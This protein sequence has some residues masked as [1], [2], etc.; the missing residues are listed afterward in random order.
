M[1]ISPT[2]L[3]RITID[4]LQVYRNSY[5]QYPYS[6]INREKGKILTANSELSQ[7]NGFD[8]RNGDYI[9]RVGDVIAKTDSMGRIMGNKYV[10]ES[11]L[12]AGSFGQVM[13]CLCKE[14]YQT[15]AVKVI[16]NLPAYTKQANLEARI[17]QDLI[18]ADPQNKHHTLR[19]IDHF[20]FKGHLC[21]VTEMHG[22]DIYSVLKQNKFRGFNLAIISKILEQILDCLTV[23]WR[24]GLI[25]SDL[26]PE[27]LLLDHCLPFIRVIDFGSAAYEGYTVFSYVQ[28]RYYRSPEVILG[29]PYDCRVDMWSVG[30]IAAELFIGHPLFPGCH[31]H[32]QIF[33]ITNMLGPFPSEMVKMGKKSG[34]YYVSDPTQPHGYRFATNEEYSKRAN[35]SKQPRA[36][37]YVQPTLDLTIEAHQKLHSPTHISL[38]NTPEYLV[39]LD[40]IKRCL[41]YNPYDR[42][43]P[44]EALSHPFITRSLHHPPYSP[45]SHHSPS[46]LLA[47]SGGKSPMTVNSSSSSIPPANHSSST[48]ASTNTSDSPLSS[49]QPLNSFQGGG[50][51]GYVDQSQGQGQG[52]AEGALWGASGQGRQGGMG[53][54]QQNQFYGQGSRLATSWTS[55]VQQ[56]LIA[57]PPLTTT[58]YS[59]RSQEKRE[60][61]YPHPTK[62]EERG[63]G[64]RRGQGSGEWGRE[65]SGR[66]ESGEGGVE[67]KGRNE[68]KKKERQEMRRIIEWNPN[69]TPFQSKLHRKPNPSAEEEGRR[70]GK[71]QGMVVDE[72][73]E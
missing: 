32:D 53:M 48:V 15:F 40:F 45:L 28:S 68:E 23:T 22:M 12:G 27:N 5:P 50:S 56:P 30:C 72:V 1:Q 60:F 34:K 67:G 63:K 17:L 36:Y 6:P 24:I 7:P 61:E 9:F 20:M 38:I 46:S 10:V 69:I 73:V 42:M 37:G 14:T 57:F 64:G 25:H 49:C 29:L 47:G 44:L 19:L 33:R 65:E 58:R 16:K 13:R 71:R 70:S 54:Q 2:S 4:L 59:P 39:Y 3:S 26:K 51:V 55:E 31:E 8:N 43:T 41:A 62:Q 21:F 52:Q 18:V 66:R 11:L 35:P